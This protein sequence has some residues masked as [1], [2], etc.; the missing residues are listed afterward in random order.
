[1]AMTIH[2]WG[3][4][5]HR[6]QE[7]YTTKH[8]PGEYVPKWRFRIYFRDGETW[9]TSATF[10]SASEVPQDLRHLLMQKMIRDENEPIYKSPNCWR[11]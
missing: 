5:W 1:M 10:I 8:A 7:L 4:G 9:F 2:N 11:I 6:K 3:H